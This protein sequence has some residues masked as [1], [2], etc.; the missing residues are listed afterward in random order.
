[1]VDLMGSIWSSN[2]LNDFKFACWIKSILCIKYVLCK[3]Y[4]HVHLFCMFWFSS[5]QLL[6]LLQNYKWQ[7]KLN[8]TWFLFDYDICNYT[9][10]VPW[11][12]PRMFF[13]IHFFR[14]L[15]LVLRALKEAFCVYGVCE[16]KYHISTFKNNET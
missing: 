14:I 15:L 1:M 11:F 5:F 10:L 16:H 8:Y 7:S 3:I 9:G 13:F 6:Y 4:V 2:P 12:I